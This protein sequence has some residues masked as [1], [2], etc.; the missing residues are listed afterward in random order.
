V[1]VE[2]RG[3]AG[4][5]VETDVIG[6]KDVA[7]AVQHIEVPGNDNGEEQG[8][9]EEEVEAE[10]AQERGLQG[11]EG[12]EGE[13]EGD[14]GGSL[15]HEGDG[16]AGEEEI[17]GVVRLGRGVASEFGEADEG[18][19]AAEGEED[20]HFSDAGGVQEAEGAE[21]ED[22]AEPGGDGV[23][24]ERE[25]GVDDAD[26][27]DRGE[28]RDEAGG[29]LGYAEESEAEGGEPELEGRLF[30]P[31]LGVPVGY[32]PGAGEHGAR[33]AGVDAFIPVGEAVV[34]EQG[35]DDDGGEQRGQR[36][37][38]RVALGAGSLLG[39]HGETIRD[40]LVAMA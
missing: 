5:D 14:A 20:V 8:K 33:D 40:L 1:A 26:E 29:E 17:P 6:Q 23:A 13:G 15:G 24:A 7:E 12:H 22:R 3:G 11:E 35:E 9:G 28:C 32:K 34:A 38:D 30:K 2:L 21:E 25:P 4:E 27:G 37:G 10:P 39:G 19:G 36:D 18:E 16:E 31:R